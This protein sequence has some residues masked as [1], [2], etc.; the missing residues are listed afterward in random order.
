M[1]G[2]LATSREKRL[3]LEKGRTDAAMS[4]ARSLPG[5]PAAVGDGVATAAVPVVKNTPL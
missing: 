1:T 4:W 5:G 2:A 3:R